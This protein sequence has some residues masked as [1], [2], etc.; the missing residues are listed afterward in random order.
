VTPCSIIVVSQ[1][2]SRRKSHGEDWGVKPRRKATE[3]QVGADR[4]QFL[5]GSILEEKETVERKHFLWWVLRGYKRNA[6]VFG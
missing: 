2:A 3:V 1:T 6:K 5:W 4:L